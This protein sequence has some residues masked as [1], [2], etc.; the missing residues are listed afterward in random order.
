M[1]LN[2]Q[3]CDVNQLSIDTKTEIIRE[4]IRIEKWSYHISCERMRNMNNHFRDKNH[5][6]HIFRRIEYNLNKKFLHTRWNKLDMSSRFYFI[7][8]T[9]GTVEKQN[10]HFHFLLHTPVQFFKNQ[11]YE[12]QVDNIIRMDFLTYTLDRLDKKLHEYVLNEFQKDSNE[13]ISVKPIYDT[14]YKDNVVKYHTT[15]KMKEQLFSLDDC[16][17]FFYMD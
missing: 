16:S 9:H 2:V 5:Y 15:R 13:L 11:F 4:F 8:F 14:D 7:G 3:E 17:D 10:Q 12:S 1:N 6:T